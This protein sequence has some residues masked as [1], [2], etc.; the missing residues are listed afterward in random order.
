MTRVAY[1]LAAAARAGGARPRRAPAGAVPLDYL[2]IEANEGGSSGGH[3]A[4]AV[5]D[6]VFHFQHE[7]GGVLALRRDAR[8]AFRVRYT[9]LENWPVHVVRPRADAAAVDGVRAAFARRLLIEDAERRHQD[10]LDADVALFAL[11][12]RAPA[13]RP[14]RCAAPAI[15]S[16]TGS[17]PVPAPAAPPRRRSWRC[18]S[19][20]APRRSRAAR[21][22][23]ARR[24]TGCCCRRP[25]C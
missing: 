11:A 10:G 21:R 7:P 24:W 9:L 16:P 20:W 2:Y 6:G 14:G 4:L 8:A 17:A 3:V 5:G 22:R 15:S 25:R 19:G 1:A 18:A 13:A 23:C 12:A